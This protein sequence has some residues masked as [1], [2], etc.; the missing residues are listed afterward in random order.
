MVAQVDEIEAKLQALAGTLDGGGESRP[1]QIEMAH[2]VADA[3]RTRRPLVVQAGTGTGKTWAYL[4]GALLGGPEHKVVVATATL[5]LQDQ[6]ANKDLP[7]VASAGVRPGLTWAVLKGRSNYLCRQAA[8]EAAR[9]SD[10]PTLVVEAGRKGIGAEVA[11]LLEWGEKSDTGDR[12]ELDFEPSP[13]AWGSV[14]VGSEECPG[15]QVC[16]RGSD[17]F[18]ESAYERA[19]EA[20]VVVVNLA[21]LGAHVASGGHVLAEHDVIVIDEAHDAEDIFASALGVTLRPGRIGAVARMLPGRDPLARHREAV[22]RE[23]VRL[24]GRRLMAGVTGEPALAEA[25]T[26]LAEALREQRGRLR[27]DESEPGVKAHRERAS[28][29]LDSLATDLDTALNASDGM[30]TWVEGTAADETAG[31]GRGRGRAQPV[32]RVAPVQVG[33]TLAAVLWPAATPV[34]TSAT[35][36]ARTADRLGLGDDT[37]TIDVGSPFDYRHQS[38]LYVPRL[39]DVRAGEHEA[40]A[41]DEMTFLLETAGGRTLALFTSWR[42]MKAAHSALAGRVAY[43]LLSQD[44]LPKPALVEAFRSER[45]SCLFATMGFW[46]GLDVPGETCS[47]VMIDRLPFPRPDEPLNEA[48][49]EKAG[50]RAFELIDLP[51][52]ATRLAQGAGRLIRSKTDRGVVAVLDPRLAETGYRKAILAALPPM[53]RTRQ[54]ADVQAFFADQPDPKDPVPK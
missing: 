6:L 37:K 40:A 45:T 36:A 34:L 18:A 1:G 2:A 43:R 49:R 4:V 27:T 28:K 19:R 16:P 41:H 13:A 23:L 26:D 46:Q 3:V 30:V 25:V 14:S 9:E 53:P 54:R 24:A 33:T 10:S 35:I 17:C 47:L 11:R 22:E 42:A 51:Q 12:A 21:L 7:A 50:P 29:A 15:M 31:R 44:E 48:R 8:S 38:L 32:L 39:P 52:A 20:D 5:A